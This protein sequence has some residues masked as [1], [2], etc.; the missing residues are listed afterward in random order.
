[1]SS[2]PIAGDHTIKSCDFELELFRSLWRDITPHN[3]T[4]ALEVAKPTALQHLLGNRY[5]LNLSDRSDIIKPTISHLKSGEV[6]TLPDAFSLFCQT[7]NEYAPLY[8]GV[9]S[10]LLPRQIHKTSLPSKQAS[11]LLHLRRLKSLLAVATESVERDIDTLN[12]ILSSI[13]DSS[14]DMYDESSDDEDEE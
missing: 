2:T 7:I 11:H 3:H 5:N 12:E 1:L 14:D 13:S 10:I 6:V 9:E 8:R 4:V